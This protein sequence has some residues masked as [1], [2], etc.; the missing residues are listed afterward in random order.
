M[1]LFL[2][3]DFLREIFARTW[4]IYPNKHFFGVGVEH[5]WVDGKHVVAYPQYRS[6]RYMWSVHDLD[7]GA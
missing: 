3:L 2:Q 1:P 7:L 4:N 5:F 6:S